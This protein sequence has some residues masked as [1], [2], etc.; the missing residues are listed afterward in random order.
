M[1]LALFGGETAIYADHFWPNSPV[2]GDVAEMLLDSWQ[3]LDQPSEAYDSI[4]AGLRDNSDRDAFQHALEAIAAAPPPDLA[5]IVVTLEKRVRDEH[6]HELLRAA[7]ASAILRFSIADDQWQSSAEAAIRAT[8]DFTDEYALAMI[9]R[10]ASV[11]WEHF[12]SATLIA[13][14]ERHA[15]HPQASY[16]RGVIG[17]ALAMEHEN[18]ADIALGL[19]EAAKWLRRSVSADAERRDAIVYLQLTEALMAISNHQRASRDIAIKLREEATI[20]YLWDKPTPGSEWLLPPPEAVLQWIPLVDA[21]VSVS[22][23]LT[24]P[25]W[26]DIAMSL[27]LM[28]RTYTSVR[29]VQPGMPGVERVVHPAIDAAFVQER[30][31]LALLTQWL[32]AHPD[33]IEADD[34]RTLRE[35]IGRRLRTEGK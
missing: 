22:E 19:T 15:A 4:M 28:L 10:L 16:E 5:R 1:D 20:R 13:M 21:I 12:R 26:D 2:F 8:E 25:S 18:L 23:R 7:S 3:D 9:L 34:A 32:D 29:S 24:E 17:L 6:T 14:L 27:A 35:N 30:G 11:G 33:I 31:F